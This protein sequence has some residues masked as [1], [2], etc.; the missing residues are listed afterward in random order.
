MPSNP[1]ILCIA[2]EL[3]NRQ[4][5]AIITDSQFRDERPNTSF[6]QV[7][8]L[9]LLA[10]FGYDPILEGPQAQVTPPY[11][12][13]VRDGI[14]EINGQ[15][16]TRY[17]PGPLFTDYED[18]DGNII[19]AA[20]QQAAYCQHLDQA[21]ATQIRSARNQRLAESDWTQLGDA[22]V[23]AMLWASYRQALRDISTQQGFPWRIDWPT[24]PQ[25]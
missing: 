4:T 16:F 19:T 8:T 11:E 3:R 7:L 1:D 25:P 17:V 12:I 24:P 22:P 23:D 14:E 18:A 5:G 20:Q 2:M 13:S 21:Q 6:P 10:S 15:W 9:D